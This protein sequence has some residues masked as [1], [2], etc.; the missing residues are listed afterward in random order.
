MRCVYMCV[1]GG[2]GDEGVISLDL[3]VMVYAS[4]LHNIIN[5]KTI[6]AAP[7]TWIIVLPS[8]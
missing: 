2:G 7:E 5:L 1:G 3:L 6:K 4:F 8:N